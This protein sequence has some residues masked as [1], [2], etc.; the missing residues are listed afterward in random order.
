MRDTDLPI[1]ASI[2]R[3]VPE[4]LTELGGPGEG[5]L[6]AYGIDE[7]ATVQHDA[8]VSLRVV[9]RLIEDAAAM[10]ELPDLGL[11]LAARQDVHV[12]GPLAIAMENSRTVGDALDCASRF[13]FVMSPALSHEVIADPLGNPGVLAIRFRYAG[14]TGAIAPQSIDYGVGIVHRVMMLVSGGGPYGLRSVQLPHAALA[15]AAVYREHFGA[16]VTFDSPD[17]ILRFPRH[18]LTLP[19]AGG[20]DL[21][22]D[23]AVDFL[24]SHFG[25][26][27][28][29]VTDLVTAI[30]EGQNGPDR[31]DLAKVAR[32]LGLHPR[33]LQRRLVEEGASFQELVDRVRRE[34]ARVL[35]TTSD[36]PFSRIA[37]QVGLGEQSSLTRAVRRWFGTSPSELR[38]RA[39]GPGQGPL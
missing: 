15:P 9:E 12:L 23:I 34:Q 36:L 18:L 7:A 27:E 5:F 16:E 26:E 29:P 20:N 8:F 28:V 39:T 21:L 14:A 6:E 13:L 19:V 37:V 22:R 24:E 2:L 38:R 17:A 11:R 32:L 25:H 10:L 3:G 30:L 31:P 1:R 35:I 33:T 4:L